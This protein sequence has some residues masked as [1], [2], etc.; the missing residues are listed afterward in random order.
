MTT[1]HDHS[2]VRSQVGSV[3]A[4]LIAIAV[5]AV[6]GAALLTAGA[7]TAQPTDPAASEPDMSPGPKAL[8]GPVRRPP[9]A[10][11]PPPLG[12]DPSNQT[13]LGQPVTPQV[14]IPLG[15]KPAP[16]STG[17]VSHPA[18]NAASSP[19]MGDAAAR[20]EAMRGEQSRLKCLDQ[21]QRDANRRN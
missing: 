1:K 17:T 10:R 2:Q 14:R 7:A 11:P 3:R 12:S 20:C 16:T 4:V 15:R 21:L 6:A 5:T 8:P 9:A 13:G 19:V 18:G